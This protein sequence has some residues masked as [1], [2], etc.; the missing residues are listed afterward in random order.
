MSWENSPKHVC[1]GGSVSALAF[2]C[3]TSKICFARD[4][5]LEKNHIGKSQFLALKHAFRNRMDKDADLAVCFGSLVFCCKPSRECV[6]R[7]RALQKINMS[8][9]E[10]LE[11]K[12]KMGEAFENLAIENL[13]AVK[14][15]FKATD[16]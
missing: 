12:K 14:N 9:K 5:M 1:R 4:A 6:L 3:H 7:D 13:A 2:C 16:L 15:E 11:F 10:Y 8:K